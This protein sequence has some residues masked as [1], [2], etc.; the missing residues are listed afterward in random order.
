MSEDER[1]PTELKHDLGIT[2]GLLAHAIGPKETV[3]VLNNI[4]QAL[5]NIAEEALALDANFVTE[6]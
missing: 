5:I 4:A 3:H 2:A 1:T 6:H